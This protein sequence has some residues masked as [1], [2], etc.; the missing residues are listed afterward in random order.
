MIVKFQENLSIDLLRGNV[1][2]IKQK[3]NNTLIALG[4]SVAGRAILVV[5]LTSDLCAKGMDAVK[6]IREAAKEIGGSG[7]GR[8]DFAQAGGSSPQ[9]FDAAFKKIKELI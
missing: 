2:L 7:G 5:A 8:P 6:I 3:V 1:D 4:T 9:N